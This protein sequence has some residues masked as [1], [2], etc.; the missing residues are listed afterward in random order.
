LTGVYCRFISRL[1]GARLDLHGRGRA[2]PRHQAHAVGHLIDVEAHRDALRQAYPGED[3]V[4]RGEPLLVGLGVGD[5]DAAA[6]RATWPRT[7]RL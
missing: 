4:D 6:M 3:R 1:R 7:S 5:V 2:P